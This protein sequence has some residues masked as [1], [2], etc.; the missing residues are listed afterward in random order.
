ME[1]LKLKN[2]ETV[3]IR[4]ATK[5]DAKALIKYINTVSGE[6]DNLTFGPGEFGMNVEQE[7]N[8]LDNTAK[9]NNAIYLIAEAGGEIVG[10]LNFSGGARPR[11][12]HTGEFG[13]SVLKEYWGNGIGTELIKYLI[14][15][16]KKSGVIRKINLRVRTDNVSA[17]HVYKKLGFTEEG[18]IIR[19]FFINNRFYDSM[20]MGLTID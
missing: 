13:V 17:I 6:S 8:F 19:E 1:Q 5:S 18:V 11:I 7:E 15:W 2:G 12:A 9:Q 4:P 3:V 20:C 14:K 16:S 10:S